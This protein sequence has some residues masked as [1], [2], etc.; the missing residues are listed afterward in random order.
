MSV[1]LLWLTSE[2]SG[3]LRI[4]DSCGHS[5]TRGYSLSY[6][7]TR[8]HAYIHTH[9]H[10]HTRTHINSHVHRHTGH[11]RTLSHIHTHAHACPHTRTQ[12]HTRASHT[13]QTHTHTHTHTHTQPGGH[14]DTRGCSRTCSCVIHRVRET[15]QHTTTR[16]NTRTAALE[17]ARAI[18]PM[19]YMEF[20]RHCN[21]NTLQ[22]TT[23]CTQRHQ[24]L[25]A[26]Y[27]LCIYIYMYVCM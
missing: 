5:D 23:T 18:V 25:L 21:Y 19:L 8:M 14:S 6:T 27:I 13:H 10:N 12:T 11:S 17:A 22:H 1:V 2:M 26:L 3:L 9:I 15:L 16:C 20:V 24:R 4:C 7:H